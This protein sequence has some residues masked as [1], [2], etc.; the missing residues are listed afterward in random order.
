MM[1]TAIYHML[2]NGN[3][4]DAGEAKRESNQTGS[5]APDIRR[6]YFLN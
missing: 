3:S 1:L 6:H 2:S 4:S 5:E